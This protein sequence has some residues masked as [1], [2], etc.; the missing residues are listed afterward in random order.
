MQFLAFLKP[1][2]LVEERSDFDRGHLR[3]DLILE[4]HV[5]AFTT[6]RCKLDGKLLQSDLTQIVWQNAEHEGPFVGQL[7]Q[8]SLALL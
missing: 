5:D 2:M 6:C 4:F 1:G 7:D 3:L 8:G